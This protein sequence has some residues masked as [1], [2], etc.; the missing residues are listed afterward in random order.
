MDAVI[1]A[2]VT[3][4]LPADVQA[5]FD[6]FITTEYTT[7]DGRGRPITWPVT[8]YYAPGAPCIDVTT[9]LG[10]PK[11]ADD[12]AA[13]PRV[14]LLFSD[15]TG[16]GMADPP[17]V[18]VQGIA[19]VDDSDLDANRR[20]Y[21][22]ESIEKLPGTKALHPPDFLKRFASWYYTRIY[23]HVRPERI[24]VW[25]KGDPASE[26]ELFDAHLEEVRSGHDEEPDAPRADPEGTAGAWDE[27]LETLGSAY[28]TGA[29][30]LVSPDGFPFSVRLPVRADRAAGL[31]RLG[32]APLGVPL[33][34]GLACLTVHEHAPEFTWQRN[35]QVRGDLVP[36]G[37]AWALVPHKLVGGFVVPPGGPVAM[38]RENWRKSMRF[39]RIA[40]REVRRR[41]GRRP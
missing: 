14:A 32:G 37:E 13:N 39:R 26:P 5:V 27:R 17:M 11:K 1:L 23:V 16:S 22:H 25:P 4:S 36:D 18:L 34:P 38:L 21:G 6:R 33:Q 35:F 40:K 28:P 30:S 41:A 31:I 7:V 29:I 8:P 3:A 10:Y 9:G 15:P 12:A 20:R 24:F 19:E 2:P